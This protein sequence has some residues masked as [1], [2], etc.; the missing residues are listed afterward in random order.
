MNQE[1]LKLLAKD[2]TKEYPRSPRETLA[3]YV[4]AARAVDKCRAVL[5]GIGGEYHSGCPVD[6][7]FLEFAGI[8]YE[9]FRA[10]V[11]TGAADAEIAAWI[12]QNAKSRPRVEIIRWNNGLRDKRISEMPDD[13]QEYF[14]DYVPKF[15]PRNRPVYV[16]FD[17]YDLE[18]ERI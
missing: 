7:M 5:L 18:E 14:E 16:F 10:F 1:K 15:V 9:K 12:L 8:S 17:V 3:G 4:L 13:L 6:S 11:A 2:L